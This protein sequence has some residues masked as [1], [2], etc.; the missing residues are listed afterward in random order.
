M[1][2]WVRPSAIAWST[3]IGADSALHLV[4]CWFNVMHLVAD[5]RLPPPTAR[6]LAFA[7]TLAEAFFEP[8]EQ[9]GTVERS[10]VRR[11]RAN[12]P[13]VSAVAAG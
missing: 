13:D 6:S 2:S 1:P 7:N 11:L 5:G 9:R 12:W 4:L 3:S 8:L 10:L